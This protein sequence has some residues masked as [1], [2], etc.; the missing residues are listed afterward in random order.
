MGRLVLPEEGINLYHVLSE[1]EEYY[2]NQAMDRTKGN[3]QQA[4]N[5]LGLH[6]T[7]LS[8]KLRKKGIVVPVEPIEDPEDEF[9]WL[10]VDKGY[11]IYYKGQYLESKRTIVQVNAYIREK[12][13][14]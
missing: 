5:L 9:T 1:I 4:A 2:I 8:E 3:I 10:K 11:K 13:N 14:E 6:R 12:M 7:T